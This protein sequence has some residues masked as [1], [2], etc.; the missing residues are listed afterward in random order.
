[1]THRDSRRDRGSRRAKKKT[2]EYMKMEEMKVTTKGIVVLKRWSTA[3]AVD[4]VHSHRCLQTWV[5]PRRSH[6]I[7]FF[8]CFL[9]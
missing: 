6:R 1:M 7:L 8:L 5:V 9:F 3:G 2:N 4:V